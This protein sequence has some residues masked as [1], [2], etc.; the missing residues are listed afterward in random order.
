M[1]V[2]YLGRFEQL[3]SG[4][5]EICTQ[6]GEVFE[7]PHENKNKYPDHVKCYTKKTREIVKQVYKEDFDLFGY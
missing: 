1:S 6:V 4:W 5:R 7:L 2:D 3:N